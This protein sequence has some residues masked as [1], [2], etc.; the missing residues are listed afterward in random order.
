MR[1]SGDGD[2][3]RAAAGSGFV[4]VWSKLWVIVHFILPICVCKQVHFPPR[5]DDPMVQLFVPPGLASMVQSAVLRRRFGAIH[6]DGI[7]VDGA[8][9]TLIALAL[10]TMPS[11]TDVGLN[12][13][14]GAS[15]PGATA[16]YR[17]FT[18]T[19][20]IRSADFGLANRFERMSIVHECVHALMDFRA[21][22]GVLAVA[23]EAAAYVAGALFHIYDTTPAGGTV[24]RPSWA[25][26]TQFKKAHEIAAA[27]R[28]RPGQVVDPTDAAELR[29]EI[30]ARPV[31]AG[32][33]QNPQALYVT[34]GIRL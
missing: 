4:T 9:L 33:A 30:L 16:S 27:I 19:F 20:I 7:H 2:G 21:P 14:I 34:D 24:R 17:R 31:Y 29:Q 1:R 22:S 15:S 28:T 6:I 8:G 18:N 12:I 32:L 26:A 10:L 25:H 5:E 3:R 11:G 13:S 23:N